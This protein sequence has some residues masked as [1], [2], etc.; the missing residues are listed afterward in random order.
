LPTT[1]TEDASH[2][3]RDD[4]QANLDLL[5]QSAQ[6]RLQ[7]QLS[8]ADATDTK[9]LGLLALGAAAIALLVATHD[10]INRF[11]WIPVIGFGL[12]SAFLV[13]AARPREFDVGPDLA[14]LYDRWTT[15]QV[16]AADAA[17]QMLSELLASLGNNYSLS[18]RK[19]LYVKLGLVAL[20]ISSLGSIPV[21]LLRPGSDF[22]PSDRATMC[23]C[24]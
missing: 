10:A 21:A 13:L 19:G 15:A 6:E 20:V 5:V 18:I 1:V 7:R 24:R 3:S 8:D 17:R 11:W 23:L 22:P 4:E 16:S 14:W 9:A 12:A 2:S